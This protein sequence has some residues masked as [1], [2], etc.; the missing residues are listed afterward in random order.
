M[1]TTTNPM[2]DYEAEVKKVYP[3]A[4]CCDINRTKRF[5]NTG[6]HLYKIVSSFGDLS[7]W[8]CERYLAWR[9]AYE[10]LKEKQLINP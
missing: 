1:K 6:M 7:G 5:F 4:V 8:K 3:E 10:T 2:T 9:S